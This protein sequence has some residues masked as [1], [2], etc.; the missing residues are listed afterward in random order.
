MNSNK[1]IISGKLNHPLLPIALK[2][3]KDNDVDRPSAHEIC[4]EI[5][6][7]KQK[8]N[9]ER[10]ESVGFE[11]KLQGDDEERKESLSLHQCFEQIEDLQ[12]QIV[13]L[14][15]TLKDKDK[16]IAAKL[17][18][19]EQL[20]K[21]HNKEIQVEKRE[22][23]GEAKRE[24]DGKLC[25][26]VTGSKMKTKQAD[27]KGKTMHQAAMGRGSSSTKQDKQTVFWYGRCYS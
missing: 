25:E 26:E 20:K 10:N 5:A 22:K 1:T 7:L 3:L 6:L 17:M 23:D 8:F 15:A 19:I 11:K 18:E 2:C 4:T 24:F 14:E 9:P 27:D 21:S 12:S 16:T 13:S